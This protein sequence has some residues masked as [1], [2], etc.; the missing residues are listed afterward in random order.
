MCVGKN[1]LGAQKEVYTM[2]VDAERRRDSFREGF[3][4]SF[5]REDMIEPY[6]NQMIAP[7]KRGR[8]SSM[9]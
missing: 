6:W 8:M 5:F 9:T 7:L 3:A 1:E 2:E 4:R